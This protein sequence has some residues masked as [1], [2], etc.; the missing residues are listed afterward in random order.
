MVGAR[1]ARGGRVNQT[2]P[3]TNI[4]VIGPSCS[5]KSTLAR[6]L[7][8]RHALRFVELDALFWEP[9]WKPATPAVFRQR[10]AGAVER[11]G[12]V[13][14]GNYGVVR[15]IIW[16]RA[17]TI[18]WLDFPLG[19]VLRRMVGRTWRRWR[20]R[21]LLWGTNRERFWVQFIPHPGRSLFAYAVWT[22][23][24]RRREFCALMSGSDFAHAEWVRL[25]SPEALEQW[26]AGRGQGSS[27]RTAAGMPARR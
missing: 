21:E 22:H 15:D 1:L 6:W 5:G 19:L 11:D 7:A 18:V 2:E 4:V 23:W 17:G 25:C 8:E 3:A 12:W 27:S 16:P 13:V 10:V 24:R 14:A 26:M 20:S 9:G